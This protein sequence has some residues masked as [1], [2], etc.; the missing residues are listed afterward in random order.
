[1]EEDLWP[2]M[3]LLSDHG[4]VIRTTDKTIDRFTVC[5]E[6]KT[7]IFC[8]EFGHVLGLKDLYDTDGEFS[9]GRAPGLYGL[10][11]MDEGCLRDTPPDFGAPEFEQ[12]QLGR[13]DTLTVGHYDLQPLLQGRTY[14]MAQTAQE[15][16]F[17]LFGNDGGRLYIYHID[18]SE[19]PAGYSTRYDTDLSAQERWESNA[20]NDN[21]EHP[22]ARLVPADPAATGPE[23]LFFPQ[24]GTTHFGSDS[25]SPFRS[26]QGHA[27]SLALTGIRS[28]A[29][30]TVSFDVIEPIVLTDLAVFQDAAILNWQVSDK[31]TGI[32]GIEVI[33]S[34]GEE[35]FL[36]ELEP[37]ATHCTLEGLSP[38][39][40]YSVT[41]RVR[42]E[43]GASFSTGSQFITK[44]YRE[45]TYPYIYLNNITRNLDGSFQAGTKI[46]LRVFNA[47]DV[48]D[49]RWT[50]DGASINPGPDGRF[51]LKRS[52]TLKA[53]IY[54]TDG[55]SE[56]ILKE[57]IVQ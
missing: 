18:K 15:D 36:L 4:G 55:S 41:V 39:T 44:I 46:P 8:H 56:T 6:G 54:H 5:P 40:N 35:E 50:L 30:G 52:G 37:T 29:G 51:T 26:W 38:R 10:S 49:V 25:P 2:Q 20:V 34:D 23:G 45:G 17:F 47:T 43:D 12:L 24:A 1:A 16:E 13:C 9:G 48:Q 3:A 14:I 32:R 21:P 53:V 27:S 33:R 19:N 22:C 42:T 57:I 7:G 31:L 11:L 28:G